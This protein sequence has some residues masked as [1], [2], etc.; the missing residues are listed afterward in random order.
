[1]YL[2]N[3]VQI[4]FLGYSLPQNNYRPKTTMPIVFANSV[5]GFEII[6]V[7]VNILP[8]WIFLGIYPATEYL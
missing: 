7:W 6:F 5:S 2:L 4:I 1:M 3:L 8:H